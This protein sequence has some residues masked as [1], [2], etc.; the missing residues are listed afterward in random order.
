EP[1]LLFTPVRLLLGLVT[2]LATALLGRAIGLA[3]FHQI[4]IVIAG[5][6]AFV[7]VFELI[8]PL[9]IVGRDPERVLEVLLPSFS[10]VARMFAPIAHWT[11]RLAE[12][13]ESR[14]TS[15]N[16]TEEPTA[17]D[18]VVAPEFEG[19]TAAVT[20]GEE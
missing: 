15:G 1:I 16:A 6:A 7:L 8:V 14:T 17:V 13:G 12:R 20:E 3:A 5:G 18:G 10:P 9:L 19:S 11:T 4:V 2:V